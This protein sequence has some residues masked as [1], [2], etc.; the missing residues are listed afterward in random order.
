MHAMRL[1]LKMYG[2]KKQGIK[3]PHRMLCYLG[4]SEGFFL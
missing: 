1:F 2:H 3:D 4:I